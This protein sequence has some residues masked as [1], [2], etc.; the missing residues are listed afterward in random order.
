MDGNVSTLAFRILGLAKKIVNEIL[1]TVGFAPN[2]QRATQQTAWSK[3]AKNDDANQVWKPFHIV[4]RIYHPLI[5]K[6][7]SQC[8][9]DPS[10]LT[11]K[12]DGCYIDLPDW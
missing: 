4:R 5:F 9:M 11:S 2:S 1:F 3:A 8:N 10:P 7:N 6:V 12:I